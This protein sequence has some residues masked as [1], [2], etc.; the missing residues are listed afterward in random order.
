MDYWSIAQSGLQGIGV[1][2]GTAITALVSILLIIFGMGAV[3]AA[4]NT[5][6]ST[7]E[8]KEKGY[9][10]RPGRSRAKSNETGD[11]S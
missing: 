8:N 11:R 9:E 7:E 4:F 3:R 2:V 10:G 6:G 5:I 1:D